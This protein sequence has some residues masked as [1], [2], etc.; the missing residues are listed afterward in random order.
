MKTLLWKDYRQ[1]RKVLLGAAA[2]VLL[3]YAVGLSFS[4][5]AEFGPG[6]FSDRLARAMTIMSGCGLFLAAGMAAFIA[7]NALAG[8]R[9]DRSAEFAGYLPIARGRSL[10][11]KLMVAVASC[12]ALQLVNVVLYVLANPSAV[13]D[14]APQISFLIIVI[15]CSSL[16]F[17][18]AWLISS[19]S[20]SPAMAAAAALAALMVLTSVC[21]R[22]E[23]YS[24]W[25]RMAP[26]GSWLNGVPTFCVVIGLACFIAGCIYY[27]RRVEP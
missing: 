13:H 20:S 9:A 22:M 1:G 19:F 21:F 18:V 7:G 17:G 14:A 15:K 26:G 3:P 5:T 12:A 11:S 23:Y 16:L 24:D 27:L 25:R 8:E 6:R 4:C 10:L 2:L